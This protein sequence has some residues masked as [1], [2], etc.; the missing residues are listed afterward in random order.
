MKKFLYSF[1]VLSSVFASAQKTAGTKIAVADGII[2][3]VEMFSV[4]HKNAVQ[5]SRTY[6]LANLP[7]NLKKFSA[8]AGNG[9][10]EYQL[11]NDAGTIDRLALY[12][13]NEQFRLPKDTPVLIDGKEVSDTSLQ[14]Y[15]DLLSHMK[16]T[17]HNG[18]K[19]V[20]VD[21]ALKK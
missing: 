21:T 4:N 1:L 13:L 10:V 11:K 6:T 15:G 18:K 16:L 3:T 17:D 19:S 8:L 20:F 5:N 12:Q 2:G 14:I 7:Q 9:L